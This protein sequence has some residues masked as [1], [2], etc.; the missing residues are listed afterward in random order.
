MKTPSPTAKSILALL[1]NANELIVKSSDRQGARDVM[2]AVRVYADNNKF[3]MPQD[4]LDSF[5]AILIDSTPATL[6]TL[7][8]SIANSVVLFDQKKN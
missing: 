3:D 2:K 8:K 4:K 5:H 7:I 6:T 1:N